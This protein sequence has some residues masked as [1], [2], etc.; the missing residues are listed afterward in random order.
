MYFCP[1]PYPNDAIGPMFRT[2][3]PEAVHA[4]REAV[5]LWLIGEA[6]YLC[7]NDP[8]EDSE[9]FDVG[10][11][12]SD[13]GARYHALVAL[14]TWRMRMERDRDA[15]RCVCVESQRSVGGMVQ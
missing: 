14:F 13:A 7:P 12:A 3:T 1:N 9:M 11:R 10:W 4:Y 2:G 8:N 6:E 15:P 5:R